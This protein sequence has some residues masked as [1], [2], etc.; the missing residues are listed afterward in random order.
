VDRAATRDLLMGFES[1][2]GGGHGCEFGLLQREFGAEPMGLFRW[3]DI[4]QEQLS[5]ALETELAGIGE[6]RHTNVFIPPTTARPEY[7]T[8]DKRY[9]MAM[10]CFVYPDETPRRRMR[11][12]LTKRFAF[13]RRKLLDDLRTGGKIFVYKNMKRNLADAELDRLFAACRSYGRNTLLYIRYQ[14]GE[15]PNGTVRW[16]RPGLL[17]GYIDHFSH[18]PD[19]DA[20]IGGANASLLRICREAHR[21]AVAEGVVPDRVPPGAAPAHHG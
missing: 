6:P 2:G 7:W 1:L 17:V 10:R 5:K 13:L 9:H 14:D 15:H 21:L 18:T 20:F 11:T 8:T 19:T 4:F 16:R 3:A 12:L